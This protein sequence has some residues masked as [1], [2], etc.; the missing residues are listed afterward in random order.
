MCKTNLIYLTLFC[1]L[2]ALLINDNKVTPSKTIDSQFESS[3][4]YLKD[5]IKK[6]DAVNG[7]FKNW[8]KDTFELRCNTYDANNFLLARCWN[9]ISVA[10]F[11][12]NFVIWQFFK[13]GFSNFLRVH[14]V[15]S[16]IMNFLWQI[17]FT[18][19]EIFM[20]LNGQI[21]QKCSNHLVTLYLMS[22]AVSFNG[23]LMSC[24]LPK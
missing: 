20:M 13:K 5:E 8:E 24:P 19:W 17:I 18:F 3:Q 2:I 7:T 14:L 15:F 4:S 11:C 23:V 12:Q 21:F 1:Y 22:F 6:T 10:R 9:S 16:K